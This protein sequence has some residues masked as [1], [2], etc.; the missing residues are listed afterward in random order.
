[1][2][3]IFVVIATL[4]NVVSISSAQTLVIPGD[5]PDPSV[6]KIGDRYYASAT[7]SNWAPALPILESRDLLTWNLKGHV[8]TSLPA[9]ADF[10][11]W[12]PEITSENGKVLVYYTAHKKNGNLCV[13]VA[14]ADSINGQFRDHGP[15]I[16][17]EAGSIDAFEMRD[18][19]G[20]PVW[21][22]EL[23]ES[24]TK[25]IG[26]KTKLFSNDQKWEGALVEGVSMLRS[27]KYYY[28]LFSGASCCGRA[29]SYGIGVA[30]ATSLLGPWEKYA[31]NPLLTNS[32]RWKC[33]GHGTPVE[34]DGRYYFLHH[35][36]D[37]SGNVFTGRQG[38]LT[39]F[40]F[41]DDAWIR[42]NTEPAHAT[43]I[44]SEFHDSFN[45]TDLSPYWQWSVF[46]PVKYTMNKGSLRLDALPGKCGAY[47]GQRIYTTDYEAETI[48]SKSS[49]AEAGLAL[50]GDDDNIIYASF[51]G[52]TL[53]IT[54]VEAGRETVIKEIRLR[55]VENLHLKVRVNNNKD[56]Q[57]YWSSDGANYKAIDD[58]VVDVSFLPP[59]DRAIR[60]GIISKG[61]PG[62]TAVIREF[63][64]RKS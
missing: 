34:K 55:P 16:C 41:T 9:W 50:I 6:V 27:G 49:D 21:A 17:Q 46:Q 52:R 26:E 35:A 4:L 7:S 32:G 64:L 62:Q 37:S 19:T 63:I 51:F 59:W 33:N 1:M 3:R 54:K 2:A 24:R 56:I 40:S 47:I 42:F 11:F 30:R 28:A 13:A 29:C 44:A 58:S 53:K 39:E 36:Y 18:E 12:A 5:Y 38:V 43:A 23:N 14:S 60:V 8:F 45:G 20:K 31:A 61:Q 22:Q 15:I 57:F 25:L 10:Y 48:I